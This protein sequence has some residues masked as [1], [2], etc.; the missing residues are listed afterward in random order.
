[1]FVVPMLAL[2]KTSVDFDWSVA[3]PSRF[4]P[5]F[6][7]NRTE[8]ASSRGARLRKA[9]RN[10]H[11]IGTVFSQTGRSAKSKQRRKFADRIKAPLRRDKTD[12]NAS[13]R[14]RR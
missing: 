13:W 14:R 2:L 9:S 11:F 8:A 12:S 10:N 4:A 5:S 6:S 7:V 3:S 1:M